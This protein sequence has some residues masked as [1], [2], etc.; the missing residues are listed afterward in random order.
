M[1]AAIAEIKD[2]M[3][4]ILKKEINTLDN[5][6]FYLRE[7]HNQRIDFALPPGIYPM[8]FLLF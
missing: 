3:Q 7:K 4:K 8:D 6:L 1:P 5:A 2:I